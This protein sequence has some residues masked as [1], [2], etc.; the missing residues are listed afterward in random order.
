MIP[1]M[2]DADKVR[3]AL[4]TGAPWSLTPMDMDLYRG[5][6]GVLLFLVYYEK[7]TKSTRCAD[8]ILRV[9]FSLQEQ[10]PVNGSQDRIT[11]VGVFGG[12][13]GW[14]YVLLHLISQPSDTTVG[15]IQP[16]VN[17]LLLPTIERIAHCVEKDEHYDIYSGASGAILALLNC[18]ELT[19]LPQALQVAIK[20][21]KHLIARAEVFENGIGWPIMKVNPPDKGFVHG[22]SGSAYAL[23]KLFHFTEDN[24]FREAFEGTIRY[25]RHLLADIFSGKQPIND[26]SWCNGSTGIGLAR[27]G[28]LEYQED[29]QLYAELAILMESI[30]TRQSFGSHCLCHGGLGLVDFLLQVKEKLIEVDLH[31]RIDHF[32]AVVLNSASEH[33]W[34]SG[35]PLPY[36]IDMIGFMEGISGI[37]FQLLRL[38]APQ[39][40][41]SPLI[42]APP[43]L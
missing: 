38:V 15:G 35:L 32:I 24:A 2:K 29:P 31:H 30:L 13:G 20:C 4:Q 10:M 1:A 37:G 11:D 6:S 43:R 42:V 26:I 7:V 28:M 34:V 27:L 33:G 41:P 23:L 39:Q 3:E 12:L 36:R 8:L 16:A 21:G 25:E 17:S 14:L 5:L 18:Y 9:W 40:V 19:G 22:V